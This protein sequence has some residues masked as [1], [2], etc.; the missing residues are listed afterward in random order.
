M[1]EKE[2]S[3]A[4]GLSRAEIKELREKYGNGDAWKRIP[5]RKP[6]HLWNVEWTKEG[7]DLLKKDLGIN[8][9]EKVILPEEKS[10]T[11]VAKHRNPR[12]LSVLVDGQNTTVLCKDSTKFGIG[13]PVDLRWDGGRWVVLRHP[14]FNGKY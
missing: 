11:V 8:I 4:F 10:G 12:I 7:V 2:I 6:E 3:I 14:R 5:S 9:D 13:M 1:T